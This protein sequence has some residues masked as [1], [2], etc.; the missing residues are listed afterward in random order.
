MTSAVRQA[1]QK[2]HRSAT[3]NSSDALLSRPFHPPLTGHRHGPRRR[4]RRSTPNK[5]GTRPVP[6]MP[7]NSGGRGARGT[8]RTLRHSIAHWSDSSC[9]FE[10]VPE[11]RSADRPP[12]PSGSR[13]AGCR[14][15]GSSDRLRHRPPGEVRFDCLHPLLAWA[16]GIEFMLETIHHVRRHIDDVDVKLLIPTS[17]LINGTVLLAK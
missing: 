8:Q 16:G 9:S 15:G 13:T 3:S 2:R 4:S 11:R 1:I 10:R 12:A 14:S 6:S 17:K 5:P 7:P